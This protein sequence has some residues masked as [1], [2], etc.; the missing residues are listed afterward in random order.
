[1]HILSD[2]VLLSG[3]SHEESTE[4]RMISKTVYYRFLSFHNQPYLLFS[5]SML[6]KTHEYDHQT[7]HVDFGIRNRRSSVESMVRRRSSVESWE[8]NKCTK[9]TITTDTMKKKLQS[10]Y[11]ILDFT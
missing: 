6:Q 5:E 1:M 3:I 9:E 10:K 4:K 2:S 8:Q 7:L 11:F